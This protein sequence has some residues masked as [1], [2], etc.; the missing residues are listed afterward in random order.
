MDD[1]HSPLLARHAFVFGS[2]DSVITYLLCRQRHLKD[3]Q[4]GQSSFLLLTDDATSKSWTREMQEMHVCLTNI[5]GI[6]KTGQR[7][8][9]MLHPHSYL[10]TNWQKTVHKIWLLFISQSS[11][12]K[13]GSF[14]MS[15][16]FP[17][18]LNKTND[19]RQ[20]KVQLFVFF[21]KGF[22]KDISPYTLSS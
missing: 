10:R 16:H 8:L 18:Y 2:F 5:S 22:S 4:P 14:S 6:K 21:K 19:L 13:R 15:T 20:N 3:A 1:P 7:F 12:P 9:S 17:Y 11:V